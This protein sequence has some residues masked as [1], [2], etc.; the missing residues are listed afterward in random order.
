MPVKGHFKYLSRSIKSILDQSFKDFE[1]I[2]ID[3][4]NKKNIKKIIYSFSKLDNRVKIL[5]KK[6]GEFI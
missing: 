5:T 1:L 4:N 6:K 2:I 3:N